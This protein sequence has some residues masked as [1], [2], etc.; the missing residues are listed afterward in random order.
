M[1]LPFFRVSFLNKICEMRLLFE[2]CLEYEIETI[3]FIIGF[4]VWTGY[5]VKWIEAFVCFYFIW[6]KYVCWGFCL[7]FEWNLKWILALLEFDLQNCGVCWTRICSFGGYVVLDAYLT[8]KIVCLCTLSFFGLEFV[9][10]VEIL[11]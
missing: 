3:R 7:I 10:S 4:S 1:L 6:I 5:M 2:L 9:N 8:C 11:I